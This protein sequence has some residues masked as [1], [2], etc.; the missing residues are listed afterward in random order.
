MS[1]EMTQIWVLWWGLWSSSRKMASV[2]QDCVSQRLL[3]TAQWVQ[4]KWNNLYLLPP[5]P[6]WQETSTVLQ[7]R[8]D[9]ELRK[10]I[11]L[12]LQENNPP[13]P[14]SSPL[15]PSIGSTAPPPAASTA[16]VVSISGNIG[17]VSLSLC[18]FLPSKGISKKGS[19][20]LW[21]CGCRRQWAVI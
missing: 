11:Q 21:L 12:S 20:H 8:E 19:S 4:S 7:S 13:A 9:E 17:K 18:T 14:T 2:F 6:S 16:K 3:L 15:Y 10:A 1:L 5:P